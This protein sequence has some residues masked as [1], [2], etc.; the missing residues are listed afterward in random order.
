MQYA[1]F[2]WSLILLAIWVLIYRGFT[3]HESRREMLWVSLGSLPLGLF[4]WFFVP[5]YWSPPTLFDLAVRTGF[6]IETFIFAFAGAGIVATVYEYIFSFRHTTI[7]MSE[8]HRLRHQYHWLALISGPVLFIALLVASDM[9]PIYALIIAPAV[10]GIFTWYCR[11]D[12][13]EK[14]L[15]SAL[16]FFGI[17]FVYF[18]SLVLV[19]PDYVRQVWNIPAISG[20]LVAGIP[21]EEL[22]FALSVGFFWSSVYEHFAWRRTTHT[23][24]T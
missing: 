13:K 14:M 24:N 8:R 9:N 18:W 2:I 3:H 15:V 23:A 5:A 17:Y 21:L 16:L 19:F 22:L 7:S 1:Y 6:D 12:I 11:P 10:G 20:I 4:E